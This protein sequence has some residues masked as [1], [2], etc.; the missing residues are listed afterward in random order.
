MVASDRPQMG[1]AI[2]K[3]EV[4]SIRNLKKILELRCGV[5][6]EAAALAAERATDAAKNE[7]IAAAQS[8]LKTSGPAASQVEDGVAADLRFH[9][10]VNA[11]TGNDY[12]LG[13]FNYLGASLRETMLAGRLKAIERG[14]E[15]RQAV[16]EHLDVATAISESDTDRAREMMRLHLERS[17]ARLLGNLSWEVS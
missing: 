5:E 8:F 4:E 1:F 10:A 12:Y 14:G 2:H 16:Q 7:V 9:R 15:S 13:L 3:Q 11:A 17:A 6:I